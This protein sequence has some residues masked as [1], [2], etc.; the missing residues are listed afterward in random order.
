MKIEI[1]IY[2]VSEKQPPKQTQILMYSEDYGWLQ[3]AF[4]ILG[5]V[6]AVKQRS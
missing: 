2:K 4:G 1:E 6:D 5:A 3:G